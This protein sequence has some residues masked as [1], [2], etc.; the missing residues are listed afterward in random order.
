MMCH[1]GNTI[2]LGQLKKKGIISV[3]PAR[4]FDIASQR[5]YSLFCKERNPKKVPENRKSPFGIPTKGFS[6]KNLPVTFS[7]SVSFSLFLFSAKTIEAFLVFFFFFLS[8]SCF[9][10]LS[11]VCCAECVFGYL[12]LGLRLG[13]WFS[14]IFRVSLSY[15]CKRG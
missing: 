1:V 14:L 7:N 5:N 9:C 6:K 12:V 10:F 8:V 2:H 3:Y 13:L 15:V 4:E 11:T